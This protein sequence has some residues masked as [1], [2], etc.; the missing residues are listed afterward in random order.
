M[1]RSE[2]QGP[3]T[4]STFLKRGSKGSTVRTLHM[5]RTM[6]F[7][8]ISESEL[9]SIT[10][11]NSVATIFFSLATGLVTFIAGLWG[12]VVVAGTITAESKAIVGIVSIVCGILAAACGAIGLWGWRSR[13]SEFRKISDESAAAYPPR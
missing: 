3:Q 5:E 2:N 9:N 10:I 4:G 12:N 1:A 7:Y 11:F 13:N 6:K 8:P